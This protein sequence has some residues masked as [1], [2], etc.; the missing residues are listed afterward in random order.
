M[1]MLN[2]S[3]DAR[4]VRSITSSVRVTRRSPFMLK[5]VNG[6]TFLRLFRVNVQISISRR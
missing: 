6:I 5:R 2:L 3:A 1:T 4:P